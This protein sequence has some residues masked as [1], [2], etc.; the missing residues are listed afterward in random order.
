M[1]HWLDRAGGMTR[2]RWGSAK[3]EFIAVQP[4]LQRLLTAGHSKKMSFEK[5]SEAGRISMSYTRFC[6]LCK[7]NKEN[8]LEGA[9]E[10]A[11][12]LQSSKHPESKTASLPAQ[13]PPVAAS[14]DKA[15]NA[16][17]APGQEN[18][19]ARSGPRIVGVKTSKFG[20]LDADYDPLGLDK[21]NQ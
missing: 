14:S 19:T 18:A 6:E 13:R 8:R 10:R 11:P 1:A 12:A 7:G 21:E 5:L 2:L 20:E 4:E 15:A 3:V 17:A 16:L 9:P